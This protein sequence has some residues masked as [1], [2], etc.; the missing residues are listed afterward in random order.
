[1]LAP[2]DWIVVALYLAVAL[3]VGLA[4]REGSSSGRLS[5]FLADRSLPWWWAG[6]SIAATTFAADTPLAVAGIIAARGI[7]GNWLWL[8][9]LLVHAAVVV[10]FA[11]RW[12]RTGVVTDAE[13]VTLR[14]EGRA[15]EMLRLARA[16][17]Y[18]VV[19]NVIILGWVLRAMG[20]IADPL[21]PWDQWTP[22][23][24][25]A[26]ARVMPSGTALGGPGEM[27]T[28][29]LLVTVVATY[30]SLG[31]M[32]GVV[33]TDLLQFGLGML[34]SLWL[35]VAAWRAV[36]GRAGLH[37]G[38][39]RLNGPAGLDALHLF[40]TLAD[41]WVSG[42]GLGAFGFGAYLLVQA[43]ANVPADGGGYL[44]QRLN[45][46]RS[47]QDAVRAAW[48]F[49]GLQYLVRVWPWFV[50]GAVALVMIPLDG[51][52]AMVSPELAATVRGDREAAYPV[53]ML[54]LLP[55]GVLG[56]LVV[57]LLAAFMSTIDTH[58]NWGASYAVNDVVL[59]LKPDLAPRH[60]VRLARGMVLVFAGLAVVVAMQIDTIEQ[61]WKWVAALGAALGAPTLLRW[62][63]WRMTAWAELLGAGVGL[64]VSMLI[65]TRSAMAYEAQLIW[66]ATASLFTTLVV[67]GVGP[68]ADRNHARRFAER[69]GPPGWWPGRPIGSAMV[70]LSREVLGVIGVV[71][72]VV[73]GLLLGHRLLFGA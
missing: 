28:I 64:A 37:A 43:F 63:W 1:M 46:A 61:A 29:L 22:G 23:L 40:P 38:L 49:V 65:A 60:Q 18:G 56:V 5:Y 25:A 57:S 44:Q 19:Y 59:R 20:K 13:F 21:V 53:L 15:A 30:S 12:W 4:V 58:F 27:L 9:W 68:R 3:A 34:G 7:S 31:G 51:S 54:A 45:A 35:A 42:L 8:S 24:V 66:V 32:R 48:L 16:G 36:G 52:A 41:G 69:V 72:V 50:V 17:L 71:G 47:E 6:V 10:I 2:L 55:P 26:V 62:F 33:R 70:G 14:Y 73:G 39:V 11:K 67:I